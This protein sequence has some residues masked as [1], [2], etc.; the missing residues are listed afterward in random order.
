MGDVSRDGCPD[1]DDDDDDAADSLGPP[2]VGVMVRVSLSDDAPC[3]VAAASNLPADATLG[4]VSRRSREPAV[5]A[6]PTPADDD[7]RS[8]RSLRRS[9][10]CT[11]AFILSALYVFLRTCGALCKMNG[12]FKA[13]RALVQRE[14]A[15]GAG[16]D[17][18]AIGVAWPVAH[19]ADD[20]R[21]VEPRTETGIEQAAIA[22]ALDR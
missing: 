19:A 15:A 1:D 5:P 2:S 10:E 4:M 12:C 18:T 11:A 7:D 14:L 16:I 13:S 22:Q 3:P 8:L 17:R 9:E 6:T 21:D 20:A